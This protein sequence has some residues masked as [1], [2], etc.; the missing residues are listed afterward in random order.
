MSNSLLHSLLLVTAASSVAVVFVGVLRKPLRY[1]V[2]VRAAFSSAMVS[3]TAVGASTNYVVTGL[4][5]WLLGT[6][7]MLTWLVRRQRAFVR[8]RGST[9]F[10]T[11]RMIKAV[12][13][14]SDG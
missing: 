5:I 11:V 12:E 9:L 13:R 7:V 2:G 8:S 4:A 14:G 3:V 1:A 6:S 10:C